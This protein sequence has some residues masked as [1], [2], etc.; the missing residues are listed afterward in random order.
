MK[1]HTLVH[2]KTTQSFSGDVIM[3]YFHW[4][5]IEPRFLDPYLAHRIKSKYVKIVQAQSPRFDVN[6]RK[7]DLPN[8]APQLTQGM[9][10]APFA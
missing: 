1:L 9:T 5:N 4:R 8:E 3:S 10:A 6:I 2:V 7:L